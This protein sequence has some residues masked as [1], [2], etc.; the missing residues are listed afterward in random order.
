MS[1]PAILPF[2]RSWR[3][4]AL[5]ALVACAPGLSSQGATFVVD[6]F[7]DANGSCDPG[8]CSLRE[9]LLA[10]EATAEQDTVI[11][12]SGRHTLSIPPAAEGDLSTGDLEIILFDVEIIAPSGA[13]I[14]AQG[15][16]R[17]F[18][19]LRSSSSRLV[20]LTLTGGRRPSGVGGGVYVES[21]NLEL[22]NVWIVDNQAFIGGGLAI[23][24]GTVILDHVTVSDN[25]CMH[26]GG[27]VYLFGISQTRVGR[28]EVRNSTISGNH[29]D[30][31]GGAIL[32]G[33]AGQLLLEYSTIAENTN[34]P[35]D[36]TISPF[37]SHAPADAAYTLVEGACSAGPEASCIYLASKAEELA[38]PDLGL[39]ALAMNG[40][41]TPTHA[42]LLESPAIDVVPAA[43]ACPDGDQRGAPRPE[44]GDRDGEARCDAGSF[45]LSGPPV[46]EI[47]TL[48]ELGVLALIVLLAGAG[49]VALRR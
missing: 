35:G 24:L 4:W 31:T 17:V 42:L 29:A 26:T 40:G 2:S 44:D 32:I 13:V 34:R 11:L 14:D 37:L 21:S 27:G 43:A 15:I 41:L 25:A 19:F 9:A 20:N 3:R 6:R 48:G 16:D 39:E 28:L 23:E 49:V 33:A 18:R 38:V 1:S 7:D 8:D 30:L 5:I 45:E 10:A 12:P 47:P 46:V 36:A 22:E